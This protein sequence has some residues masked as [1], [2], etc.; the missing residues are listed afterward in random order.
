MYFIC[1]RV[2]LR[3]V[4]CGGR[5]ATENNFVFVILSS[6][7]RD[8]QNTGGIHNL[9]KIGFDGPGAPLLWFLVRKPGLM[10]RPPPVTRLLQ[11]KVNPQDTNAG[12][13][14]IS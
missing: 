10:G 11:T 5:M 6:G 14:L 8:H 12:F 9:G 2:L 1:V 3:G 4:P 13:M 7:L